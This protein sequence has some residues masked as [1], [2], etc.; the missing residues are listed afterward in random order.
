MDM[1][2]SYIATGCYDGLIIIWYTEIET[3]VASMKSD[4]ALLVLCIC[5]RGLGYIKMVFVY[6]DTLPHCPVDA[7]LLLPERLKKDKEFNIAVLVSSEDGH[8]LF[9][10]LST[11]KVIGKA[12]MIFIAMINIF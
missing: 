11:C 9:W 10:S 5:N 1:E 2:A 4:K 12:M 8:A 3:H 7:L 6:R